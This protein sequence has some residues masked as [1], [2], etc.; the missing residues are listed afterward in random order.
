MLYDYHR[1][2]GFSAFCGIKAAE[3]E[4]AVWCLYTQSACTPDNSVPTSQL[5]LT[6]LFLDFCQS[7]R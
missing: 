7:A 6:C 2:Y 4:A 5:L 3:Q 1:L